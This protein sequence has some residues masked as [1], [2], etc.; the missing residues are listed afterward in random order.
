MTVL[1]AVFLGTIQGLTEFLPVSSSGHLIFLPSLFGWSDQG[2][3]FDVVV[4]LGSLIAVIVYFQKKIL[5]LI[6]SFVLQDTVAKKQRMLAWYILLSIIPAGTM[7]LL[8]ESNSRSALVVGGSL[9]FWGMILGVADRFE[10]QRKAKGVELDTLTLWQSSVIALAQAVSLIPGTSRSG[11]TMTAGLFS[12]LTKKAAAEF[13]FLMSI[14]IIAAAGL[15][16]IL[17]FIE[18][19]L[20]DLSLQALATGFIAAAVSGWI[21]IA[22]LMKIIQKWSFMPF[23]VYR[24]CIGIIILATIV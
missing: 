2:I 4:H 22:G 7:G 14:P 13:S 10:K 11:I 6:R 12:G 9:I 18:V 24:I 21:A 8:L 5:Q 3:A 16:K 15:L 20:G 17:E 19:G 23:V 1:Q